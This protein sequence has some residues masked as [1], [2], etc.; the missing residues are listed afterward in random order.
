MRYVCI[1]A[2]FDV[3][4]PSSKGKGGKD[5]IRTK[6]GK[7]ER[8]DYGKYFDEKLIERKIFLVRTGRFKWGRR[9][10]EGKSRGRRKFG[11]RCGERSFGNGITAISPVAEPFL[12]Y[13][14]DIISPPRGKKSDCPSPFPREGIKMFDGGRPIVSS[15]TV[16]DISSGLQEFRNALEWRLTG[17]K[18]RKREEAKAIRMMVE[19]RGSRFTASTTTTTMLGSKFRQS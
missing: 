10:G 1:S 9:K 2:N 6:Q 3:A 14:L 19:E 8:R 15:R 4:R 18:L 13:P 7:E 11:R 17:W 12:L 5:R 16:V